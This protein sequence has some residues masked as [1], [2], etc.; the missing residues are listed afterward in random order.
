M[1]TKDQAGILYDSG[2]WKSMS[3][4]EIAIFQLWEDRLCMPFDM[5]QFA[6]EEALGRSVFTHEFAL[7]RDGLKAELIGKG[8]MPTLADIINLIPVDKRSLL[9]IVKW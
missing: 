3:A 9:G 5:F 4:R 1:M 6:V 2:F 8:T 7:N